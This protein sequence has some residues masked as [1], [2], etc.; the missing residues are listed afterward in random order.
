MSGSIPQKDSIHS[1]ASRDV[2]AFLD[3]RRASLCNR[4]RP[5]VAR[6]RR[7]FTPSIRRALIVAL[8]W[9]GI[10]QWIGFALR[11]ARLGIGAP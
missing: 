5:R 2:E 3:A 10:A 9:V 8:A 6:A 4:L 1:T 11:L 7:F